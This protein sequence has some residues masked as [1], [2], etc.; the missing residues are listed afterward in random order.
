M[1]VPIQTWGSLSS[2]VAEQHEFGTEASRYMETQEVYDLFGSLLQQLVIHQPDK[3]KEFLQDMLRKKMP[4]CLCV[5][6]PPGVSR[7]M[8]CKRLESDFGIKHIHV[9]KLLKDSGPPEA[10]D[11]IELGKLVDDA[12]V[13]QLVKGQIKRAASRGAGWILD[14]F[15]RTKVQAQALCHRSTGVVLDRVLLLHAPEAVVRQR[16]KTKLG[17]LDVDDAE[18]EQLINTRLQQYQRHIISVAE[19]FQNVIRQIAAPKVDEDADMA[20]E[21]MKNCLHV[22]IGTNAPLRPHRICIVGPC[23]S[24]RSTQSRAI[25]KS[26]GLVHVE[27]ALLLKKFLKEAG[28]LVEEIPPEYVSDEE[29]CAIVGKRL[30]EIDCIRKGWVLD[31]FPKTSAQAEFLR[32]AHRWPSRIVHLSPDE[33]TVLARIAH[34]Q[35]DPVTCTAYYKSPGNVAVRQRLV[36]AEHDMPEA[37]AERVNNHNDGFVGVRS[38]FPLVCDTVDADDDIDTVTQ[39]IQA[40]LDN[41]LLHEQDQSAGADD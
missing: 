21:T 33:D 16:Y 13:V 3:P 12:I 36:Q 4:L 32:Q 41:L 2:L 39:N 25:A 5:I 18:R 27:V 6:G 9:G 1:A 35:V 38:A 28:R 7:S 8:Y 20:Y 22:R 37:V 17:G 29:L 34:R 15:P 26:Y 30:N 14:G 40:F 24:G 19:I 10:R 23:A 11:A 31:G